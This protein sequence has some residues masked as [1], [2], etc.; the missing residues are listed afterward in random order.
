MNGEGQKIILLVDDELIICMVEAEKI[1][2]FGYKV[3]VAHSASRAIKIMKKAKGIDLV[4]MDIDLGEGIDGTEVASI[5]LK[6]LN[7]PVV[8]LSS[9]TE[10]EVVEK[11]EKITSYGYVIK[12]S[13]IAVLNAAIK[14]AFK[15]FEANQAIKA[16]KEKLEATINALPD[17]L[18]EVGLDGTIYDCHSPKNEL[19]LFPIS[20]II[21][22]NIQNSL[23]DNVTL[24]AMDAIKEANVKGF[25]IGKQYKLNVPAGNLWFELS[26]T[27]K[28][29]NYKYPHFI[30]LVRDITERKEMERALRDSEEK[31]RTVADFTYD[32]ESWRSPIGVYNYMSPS[33][34]RICGHTA[35]EF[36]TDPDLLIKI[37]HPDDRDIVEE[38]FNDIAHQSE[39]KDFKLDFRIITPSN[40]TRW[41]S[42]ACIAVYNKDGQWLGRRESNRDITER[43]QAE[44]ALAISHKELEKAFIREQQLAR[45]DALTKVHSRNY[46]FEI[47]DRE[48]NI[49]KRYELSFSIIMIDID[50]FKFVNDTYGHAIGD[51]VL[52]SVANC[53]CTEIRSTDSVGRYGGDEF[54]ILLPH[55]NA[56]EA[57]T[58]SERIHSKIRSILKFEANKG[59]ATITLSMGMTQMNHLP[60]ESIES[61]LLRAD[62]ALYK[63]KDAGRNCSI[64]LNLEMNSETEL[65]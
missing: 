38:H 55:T 65:I 56:T 13:S 27:R 39:K 2:G 16:A 33:C 40:E 36:F 10:W 19:L 29:H 5:I 61:L 34:F 22:K 62:T 15:L 47:A 1:R 46:L 53:I 44:E 52:E 6:D 7:I 49:A 4:L 17:L 60:E 63:A 11:T 32:W 18:F 43:K 35:E 24:I 12:N 59:P 14:M 51:Q 42:H 57:F 23:P 28:G 41:I 31:Y 30:A 45:T 26:V 8:F 37:T 25:S 20:D 21:G 48:F 54:I 50:F 64:I 58:L 9:H 3:I